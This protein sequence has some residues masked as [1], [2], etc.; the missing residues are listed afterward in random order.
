MKLPGSPQHQAVLQVIVDYYQGDSRVLAIILF[1]SLARGSWDHHSDIDLDI[2]LADG[3]TLNVIEEISA[4]C[5]SFSS[6]GE[7]PALIIPDGSEAADVVLQSLFQ[8]SVR[9]H[10]L[11]T[12]SPN[13]LDSLHV[14]VGPLEIDTIRQAGEANRRKSSADT[15]VL[16]DEYLR[17]AL[18]VDIALRRGRLWLALE[19]LHRMRDILMKIYSA[20]HHAT[21]PIQHMDTHVDSEIQS[22][23]MKL[24][25]CFETNEIQQAL[26]HALDL[27]DRHLKDFSTKPLELNLTQQQLLKRLQ[28]R[29]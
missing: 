15:T 1:G 4:L 18:E 11:A 2:V 9:Y 12:T 27:L 10:P 5:D 19:L 28:Q 3:V 14:I 17:Y 26:V 22:L 7:Q 25:P 24:V 21:R 8:L 23:L 29:L 13:I 16:L 6:I 20:S